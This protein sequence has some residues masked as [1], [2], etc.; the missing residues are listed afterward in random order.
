[1][2]EI[3]PF[4]FAITPGQIAGTA[5]WSLACYWAFSPLND[6]ILVGLQRWFSFAERSLYLS[7][8]EFDRTRQGRESQNA[9]FASMLGVLPFWAAGAL[10][11]YLV[12]LTLADGWS[13]SLGII[14]CM[15]G[16]IYELGRRQAEE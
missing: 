10:L 14:A 3:F 16:G 13:I 11:N 8:E 7:Q 9:F 15:G 2:L 4:Q 6:R 12:D 1:M 5:L